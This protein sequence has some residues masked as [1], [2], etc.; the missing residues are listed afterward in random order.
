[1]AA[2]DDDRPRAKITH[3]LGQDLSL[4]SVDDIEARIAALTAEIERLK[5]D[6]AKKRASRD[7]ASAFFKT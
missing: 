6:A 2:D 7:A 4:L 5:T 3:E 1:M